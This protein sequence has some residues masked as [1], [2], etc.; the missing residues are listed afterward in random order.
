MISELRYFILLK[1]QI[2]AQ[3]V[4]SGRVSSGDY[5]DWK[6]QDIV[7]LQEHLMETVNGRISEKWFYTHIKVD[8]EKLPRIDMLNLLSRYVGFDSWKDFVDEQI[9]KEAIPQKKEVKRPTKKMSFA[10]YYWLV[11]PLLL[12]IGYGIMPQEKTYHFC[13][14]DIDRKTPI[15]HTVDIEWLREG[16]SSLFFSTDEGGCLSLSSSDAEIKFVVTSPYYHTDTIVRV[17]NKDW[18]E[19]IRLKT[20]DYA[21]MI[22]ILSTSNISDWQARRNRLDK[23]L[24][25]EVEIYQVDKNGLFGIE[26]YN[27]EEFI[28]K[29]TIPT[30]NLKNI[31]I[32]STEFEQ[33]KIKE[34]RFYQRKEAS[35]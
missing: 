11:L 26:I 16:E 4:A 13:F 19:N 32:I 28:D 17:L 10:W 2:G 33:D 20:N 31:E 14:V 24:H 22:H 23:M 6:G 27:K 12:G 25:D 15:Q 18:D 35:K 21:L 7:Q 29:L 30:R 34:L 3:L 1:Q 9:S 5:T 8:N